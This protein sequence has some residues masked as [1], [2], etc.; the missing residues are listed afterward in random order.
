MANDRLERFRRNK[1]AGS[2]RGRSFVI[3]PAADLGE[4]T[5][6]IDITYTDKSQACAQ[7]QEVL[8]RL[9]HGDKEDIDGVMTQRRP[10]SYLRCAHLR[11]DTVTL[12]DDNDHSDPGAALAD[13]PAH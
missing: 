10:G 9:R 6:Q 5:L 8:D 7:L 4:K 1:G 3:P 13:T 2:G 11:T 12:T